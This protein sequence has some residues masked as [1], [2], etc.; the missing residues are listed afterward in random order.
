[1]EVEEMEE[2]VEG[3]ARGQDGD[4]EGDGT[5]EEQEEG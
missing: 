5:A 2:L 4:S 3:A 1:M